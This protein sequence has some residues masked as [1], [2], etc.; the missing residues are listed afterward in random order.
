[1][2]AF[3]RVKAWGKAAGLPIFYSLVGAVG[4]ALV[5]TMRVDHGY[6]EMS[7]PDLAATLLAAV[8]VIVALFGGLLALAALWGFSQMKEE[9]KK[10]SIEASVEQATAA[11]LQHLKEEIGAGEL[12]SYISS[13]VDRLI[14][15]KI[16]SPEMVPLIEA[17]VQKVAFGNPA[18]D[19]LLD[20]EDSEA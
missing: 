2:T 15:D 19:T 6:P 9:A 12:R 3:L 4:T 18:E 1:M 10:A 14:T 16:N 17:A 7:Y 11:A 20:E 5:T 8:S 13:E